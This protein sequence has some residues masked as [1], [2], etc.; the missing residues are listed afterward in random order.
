M[1]TRTLQIVLA[2][3]NQA[4]NAFKSVERDAKKMGDRVEHEG[5]RV[6]GFAT[7]SS[8]GLGRVGVAAGGLTAGV[9]AAAV[10]VGILT[11]QFVDSQKVS[12]QTDAVLK[13]TGGAAKVTSKH[14]S[15]LATSISRKTGIDDEAVQS[16]ENLLLTFTKIHNETGKGNKIFDRAT[17][18]ITD[19]SAALGQDTK[20]SA[21]QLGKALND[22]I[23]GV[24]A[25]QRVGVSFTAGQK[26]QIKTLVDSGKTMD[27][28]KLILRE[29][30]KEFGGSAAAIATPFD[31][32]KVSA[33]NLA[34]T[35]GGVLAPALGKAA[36]FANKFLNQIQDGTGAGGAFANAMKVTAHALSTA[37]STSVNAVRGFIRR[38]RD[39][40]NSVIDAFKNLA[41]FAKWVFEE[42]LLPVVKRVVPIFLD[43]MQGIIQA[44]RGL[45]RI[46]TGIINGDWKQAWA[47]VKD[48]VKG[49]LRALTA[50]IRGVGDLLK[51]AMVS[52]AGVLIKGLVSGLKALPGA[53][54]DAIIAGVKAGVKAAKGAVTGVLNAL[55]PF[56][57]GIGKLA[58]NIGDG[59][60]KLASPFSGLP[61]LGSFPGGLH[62]ANAALGPVAS[63][64]SGFGLAITAGRTDH[65]KYTTSGNLSYHGSGEALD[66]SNGV[67][68]P[69]ELA[70][71]QY[72]VKNF[73]GQIA[74]LIHTPLGFS[75]KDGRRVAPIDAKAHYNHVHVAMDLGR[76]GVGIGDGPGRH[77]FSGDGIGQA[78]DAAYKAGFRGE[79]LVDMVA[80]AGR[81]SSYRNSAQNLVPPD[82]SIGMW[83]INQLAHKG[84]YGT[85]RQLMN[86]Y[87]N[88]RAAWKLFKGGGLSPWQHA[89]GPLGDTNIGRAR[90]AV[91]R[92]LKGGKKG[93]GGWKPNPA[94]G[95]FGGNTQTWTGGGLTPDGPT[96]IEAS[97][98][99]GGGSGGS[100]D[101]G[102]A[103][104]TQ[105]IKDLQAAI[106][107]QVA[108]ATSVQATESNVIKKSLAD[109]MSGTLGP[110]IASR[111]LTPG[112]GVER[113]W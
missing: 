88:A 97:D 30:N 60:G 104:L 75:I 98:S 65:A 35:A 33:G 69:Q 87:T 81:E 55:N 28:Q 83:Q 111:R 77:P 73:G 113:A 108:F 10:G 109:V 57:D 48:I 31:K 68:T 38:N 2:G 16:G 90:A 72:M 79:T 1:P 99:G 96:L 49:M 43:Q 27:A 62:G 11:K 39:D 45:V 78:V 86:A 95:S 36:G 93:A 34:E 103:A 54:K 29:L 105:A 3:D 5:K 4:S 41:K 20:S 85:D 51:D 94:G 22:P 9:G 15:D 112:Y 12:K 106:D 40:I 6:H 44:V 53:I 92:Y 47:G 26:D 50:V 71:A 76:P 58:G 37:W 66:F 17:H 7:L 110:M 89:G 64:A 82:H 61:G 19:M 14:V 24:T 84:R 101:D 107:A 91:K 59:A 42:V 56:G 25:L 67:S 70:F 63:T 18:T 80:I 8:K 46:V 13:S 52:L 100:G 102:A 23:K 21:I 74:E 32:L